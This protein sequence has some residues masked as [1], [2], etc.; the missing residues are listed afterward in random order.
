M[1]VLFYDTDI[2][3][4][5]NI[6]W[7]LLENKIDVF[8]SKL[9]ASLKTVNVE[10][11]EKIS[12]ESKNF[13]F[14]ITQ[15]FSL[16]VAEGCHDSGIPYFSWIWDSPQAQLYYEQSLYDTNYVF[17]FDKR[18]VRRLQEYGLKHVWWLPLC[19]NVSKAS[20]I[21]ITDNDIKKY[22]SDIS[23]VGSLY[24]K[25]QFRATYPLL[26]SEIQGEIEEILCKNMCVWNPQ[27]SRIYNYMSQHSA[28]YVIQCMPKQSGTTS[29]MDWKFI[30]ETLLF[31]Y[32]LC[33]RDRINTLNFLSQ[34][35]KTVLYTGDVEDAKNELSTDVFIFPSISEEEAYKVFY[36]SKINLNITMPSIETGIPLRVFD[37][38]AVGGCVFSNYQEE[39]GEI[40]I[41]GKEIITF[42]N[43]DELNDKAKY[44]LSHE[45]KRIRIGVNG[46]LKV[47][48]EYNVAN[49]TKKIISIACGE[50]M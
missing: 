37:I 48:N 25:E 18:Q 6:I 10:Q 31:A 26:P 2:I 12:V 39:I 33:R 22:K 42:S 11:A 28:D 23:F 13:D 44:Y 34:K 46:Y 24:N 47:K 32:E 41:P 8:R 20:L 36:A 45:D 35:Y 43:L 7:G 38:M 19:A 29:R 5:D 27:T 16:T 14:V 17:C 3:T 15:N 9:I 50:I 4:K 40:F 30:M 1:K 21:N 49:A